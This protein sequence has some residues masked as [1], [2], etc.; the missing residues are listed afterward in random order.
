MSQPLEMG[1]TGNCWQSSIPKFRVGHKSMF[2][3]LFHSLCWDLPFVSLFLFF[4]FLH[5]GNVGQEIFATNCVWISAPRLF[6]NS[7]TDLPFAV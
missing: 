3:A 1:C 5:G 7:E 4:G 2:C 6:R